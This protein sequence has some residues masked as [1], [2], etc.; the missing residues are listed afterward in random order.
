MVAGSRYITASQYH[1][2]KCGDIKYKREVKYNGKME[3]EATIQLH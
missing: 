2:C 1:R 3:R